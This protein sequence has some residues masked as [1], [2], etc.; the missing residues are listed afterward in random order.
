MMDSLFLVVGQRARNY[1]SG[2][3]VLSAYQVTLSKPG[4]TDVV[5]RFS[6]SSHNDD[7]SR[8]KSNDSIFISLYP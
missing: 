3:L 7:N 4:V 6:Y 2:V 1:F 5:P 8:R